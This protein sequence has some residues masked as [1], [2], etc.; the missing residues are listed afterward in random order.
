MFRQGDVP[1]EFPL[2]PV[3]EVM[4]EITYEQLV[5]EEEDEYDMTI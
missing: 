1:I 3:T 5:F 4:F 2:T